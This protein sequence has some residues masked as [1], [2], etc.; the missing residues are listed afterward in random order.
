[1]GILRERWRVKFGGGRPG[2]LN[3]LFWFISSFKS[4]H[5]NTSQCR[6]RLGPE[7]SRTWW[8]SLGLTSKFYL[9]FC[10]QRVLSGGYSRVSSARG[11]QKD[12]RPRFNIEK[13]YLDLRKCTGKPVLLNMDWSGLAVLIR[14]RTISAAKSFGWKSPKRIQSVQN[15][16]NWKRGCNWGKHTRSPVEETR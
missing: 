12:L 2:P 4:G 5:G 14:M 6:H 15:P 16:M 7:C 11:S 13:L 1:M 8:I 3:K 10:H 9:L